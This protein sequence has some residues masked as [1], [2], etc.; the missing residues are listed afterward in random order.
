MMKSQ[1]GPHPRCHQK[2]PER[3][4]NK[5]RLQTPLLD[6]S[7][8][9]LDFNDYEDEI[10]LQPNPS[11]TNEEL[12]RSVH[13]VQ[14]VVSPESPVEKPLSPSHHPTNGTS[15]NDLQNEI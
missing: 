12:N 5:K 6:K 1:Y 3:V 14:A 10:W 7:F 2:F 9:M 11:R 8:G 13:A 4:N 15:V